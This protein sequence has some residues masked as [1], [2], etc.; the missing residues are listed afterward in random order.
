MRYASPALRSD[1][2]ILIQQT[3][4]QLTTVAQKS[5]VALSPLREISSLGNVEEEESKE[6]ESPL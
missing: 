4:E 2:E 5:A 3:E 6:E 1:R